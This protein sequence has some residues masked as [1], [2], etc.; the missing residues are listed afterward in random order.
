MTRMNATLE[1]KRIVNCSVVSCQDK[2]SSVKA[3]TRPWSVYILF[4]S[5]STFPGDRR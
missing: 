1:E 5:E 2:R 4:A 3:P